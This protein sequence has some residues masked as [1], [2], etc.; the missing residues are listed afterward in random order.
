MAD[1]LCHRCGICCLRGGPTLMTEDTP[2]LAEGALVLENMVCLR[3]GEWARD[4]L[5]EGLRPLAYEML[6]VARWHPQAGVTEHPW[7]CPYFE[8]TPTGALCTIYRYRPAQCDLLFCGDTAPLAERLTQ[9]NMLDR[10]AVLTALPEAMLSATARSLWQELAATHEAQCPAKECLQL[11][12]TLGFRPRGTQRAPLTADPREARLRL[13]MLART[14]AAFRELCHHKACIPAD[15]LP[16]LLGRP[17]ASLLA[18]AGC[19]PR[20]G[21]TADS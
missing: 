5:Q 20:H 18:E 15:V 21:T 2:L 16:F 12:A 7:R 3:V 1:A 6:K 9:G 8:R 4:D 10:T 17:I 14:D 11:A 13:T 19:L